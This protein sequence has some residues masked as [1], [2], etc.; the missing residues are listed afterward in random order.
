MQRAACP[1]SFFHLRPPLRSVVFVSILALAD[2]KFT[3]KKNHSF[4]V[5]VVVRLQLVKS[6][7]YSFIIVNLFLYTL[8]LLLGFSILFDEFQ[9][10]IYDHFL[11]WRIKNQLDATCYFIVLL[12]GSTSFG[13]YYAHHQELT[14][15]MLIT[16]LVVSFLVCCMLEPAAQTL[17]QPNRT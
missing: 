15:M 10:F 1:I 5:K 16:T 14:T 2:A 7:G 3:V 11:N 12:I 4:T 9:P 8:H 17:L 6:E 13:H